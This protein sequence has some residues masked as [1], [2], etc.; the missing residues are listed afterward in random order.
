[1]P[2]TLQPPS[3]K[4][5]S[6]CL[7]DGAPTGFGQYAGPINLMAN[8]YAHR[9]LLPEVAFAGHDAPHHMLPTQQ[10]APVPVMQQD[11]Q[12][13]AQQHWPNTQTIL[14]ANAPFPYPRWQ[15][16]TLVKPEPSL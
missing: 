6:S 5:P 10:T 4:T 1:M 9:S 8:Q 13:V 15:T 12:Q 2:A 7:S 16:P 14:T 11:Q 3:L